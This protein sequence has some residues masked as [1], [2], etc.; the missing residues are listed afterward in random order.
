M[1]LLTKEAG[2][3]SFWHPGIKPPG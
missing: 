2:R 3:T 1:W